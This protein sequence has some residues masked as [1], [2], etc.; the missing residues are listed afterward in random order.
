MQFKGHLYRALNPI[1]AKEP[2]SGIGAKRY[3]GR[4][5]A[6]GIEALYTSLSPETAIKESNQV[7]SLQPTTL[8]SYLA[9][10][11]PVFDGRDHG[12]ISEYSMTAADLSTN[13]WRDEMISI[14][15][16]KTQI[17]ANQ[18]IDGGYRG[19]IVP[20]YAKG[21]L[22]TDINLVLWNWPTDNENTFHLIDDENRLSNR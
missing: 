12:L 8:V 6:K 1:Y 2:L 17:F 13:T 20:S 7:G 4:F 9:N 5:N 16:S 15:K 3:G 19:L 21:A 11:S 18:L 10:I 22:A 14:G